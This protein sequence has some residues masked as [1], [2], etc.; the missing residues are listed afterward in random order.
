[1]HSLGCRQLNPSSGA[2]LQA[3]TNLSQAPCCSGVR[4][5]RICGTACRLA[6]DTPGG[7]RALQACRAR[8]S[9]DYACVTW[10]RVQRRLA[11]G[12]CA[13]VLLVRPRLA[14]RVKGVTLLCRPKCLNDG[15]SLIA[16]PPVLSQVLQTSHITMPPLSP[17]RHPPTPSEQRCWPSGP[18]SKS[19][20]GEPH[21]ARMMGCSLCYPPVY[22]AL[23]S[24]SCIL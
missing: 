8:R 11:A 20:Q 7:P 21:S 15:V 3:V 12:T 9:R 23:C 13:T 24:V 1:M 2:R 4:L 17:K 10:H 18:A 22:S 6:C 19:P 16:A 5:P 14:Y